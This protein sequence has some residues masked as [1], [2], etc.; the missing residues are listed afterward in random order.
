MRSVVVLVVVVVV[1]VAIRGW[2]PLALA[3]AQAGRDTTP[4][5]VL[6]PQYTA[7]LP[8]DH[9]D[10]ADTRTYDNRFF[11][12]DTYYEPGGPV[13]FCDFG[14]QAASVDSTSQALGEWN[15]TTSAVMELAKS[16]H[17]VVVGWEHRFY[18]ESLPVPLRTA[19]QQNGLPVTG[20]AGYRYLTVEQALEDVVYFATHLFNRTQLSNA[21]NTVLGGVGA[22]ARLDPYHTPWI[23]VGAGY[24]GNR[25]AWSRLRNP[26]VMYAVWASSAPVHLAP[27][28]SAYFDLISRTMPK[29]C[30]ADMRAVAKH[31]DA[32][33]SGADAKAVL[34]LQVAT[35]LTMMTATST[36]AEFERETLAV[37]SSLTPFTLDQITLLLVTS[38]AQVYG[39]AATLQ[40]FCDHMEAFDVPAWTSNASSTSTDTMAR[41]SASLYNPGA[42][43]A[44]P[45]GIVA[46]NSNNASIGLA[47]YMYGLYRFATEDLA[48]LVPSGS[49]PP[50][51]RADARSWYWQVL[52]ELGLV[53]APNPS[54]PTTLGSSFFNATSARAA[55][56]ARW[57]PAY[58]VGTDIPA[59]PDSSYPLSLGDWTMA[60][61]NTMFTTG[62]LDPWRAYTVFSREQAGLGAPAR[63]ITQ[64]VPACGQ[65]PGGA[66]VFGLV[67]GG[68]VHAED[69]VYRSWV[70]AGSE[71]A[72][73]P[74][75]KQG[76]AL[77][78]QAYKAWRPC[79][80]AS[81]TA[82][83]AAAASSPGP[84]GSAGHSPQTGAAVGGKGRWGGRQGA[85]GWLVAGAVLLVVPLAPWTGCMVG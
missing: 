83:A 29:N 23:W 77:F 68:A 15:G 5:Y 33:L 17:G 74:P 62:E 40:K 43:R 51:A 41:N 22:T 20:P 6:V 36:D 81:R 53:H 85:A 70:P 84:G 75:V 76:A 32:V 64:Q 35:L 50:S 79:F 18:G 34:H 44:S 37:A 27:D 28:A 47:A 19:G 69:T 48:A 7:S 39:Y 54:S 45:G 57:F 13:V 72:G 80:D 78:V 12:N 52:T 3:L 10:P 65:P 16:L 25:G 56:A 26:D 4:P 9:F 73:N 42:G 60:P 49:D 59:R 31:V 58:P 14:E 30:S 38:L 61:S 1:V 55:L 71:D 46:A 11:V 66:D 2:A 67:Y 8:V 63:P 82:A 21:N 24:S